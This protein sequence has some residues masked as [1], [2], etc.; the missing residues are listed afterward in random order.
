MFSALIKLTKTNTK[1]HQNN[2]FI[3]VMT[4]ETLDLTPFL[5]KC[6]TSVPSLIMNY[7]GY[8]TL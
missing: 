5:A 1:M 6:P 2:F 8:E 3:L 7:L 4:K